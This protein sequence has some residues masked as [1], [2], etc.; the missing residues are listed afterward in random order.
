MKICSNC[1]HSNRDTARHCEECG[2]LLP[3]DPIAAPKPIKK[4]VGSWLYS[5]GVGVALLPTTVSSAASI[6][7]VIAFIPTALAVFR[8]VFGNVT[9]LLEIVIY[10]I[11][12]SFIWAPIGTLVGAVAAVGGGIVGAVIGVVGLLVDT[13]TAPLPKKARFVLI[14]LAMAGAG[15]AGVVLTLNL[16]P[17]LSR[18]F[19]PREQL[20]LKIGAATFGVVMGVLHAYAASEED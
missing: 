8:F 10:A 1:T 20:W 3:E 19:P 2:L 7:F 4:G 18:S 9:D 15:V 13:L 14:S 12:G 16:S 17:S 6:A 5:L 11:L